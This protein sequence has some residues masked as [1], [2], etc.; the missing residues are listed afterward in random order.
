M[1]PVPIPESGDDREQK[2]RLFTGTL[3]LSAASQSL[4]DVLETANSVLDV[5][6]RLRPSYKIAER[7]FSI[8]D[9]AL[10]TAT[11]GSLARSPYRR[12]T[13]LSGF[14]PV[15]TSKTLTDIASLHKRV[16]ALLAK[17][18]A[19]ATL[20]D[21]CEKNGG[22]D[23]SNGGRVQALSEN[24]AFVEEVN[25]AGKQFRTACESWALIKDQRKTSMLEDALTSERMKTLKVTH[26]LWLGILA[27][28]G[29]AMVKESLGRPDKSGFLGGAVVS[30]VLSSMDG[31]ILRSD[32]LPQINAAS[33]RL[34]RFFSEFV[35]PKLRPSHG[36]ED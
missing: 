19:L 28:G 35:V 34:S 2:L 15:R 30:Y 9:V 23:V 8:G 21:L 7:E 17:S 29:E 32:V 33:G 10:R 31:E 11:A 3:A 4:A 5:V 27:T 20:I 18:Q 14:H 1:N 22:F 36:R 25:A 6:Q 12:R 16:S 26:V 13:F 24:L